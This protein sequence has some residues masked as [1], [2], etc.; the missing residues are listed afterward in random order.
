M[1][2]GSYAKKSMS[3]QPIE[4]DTY[5]PRR[6]TRLLPET[7]IEEEEEEPEALQLSTVIARTMQKTNEL[8]LTVRSKM[9]VD[10]YEPHPLKR[11]L[12][13]LKPL[14]ICG[15]ISVV[16][17]VILISAAALQRPGGTTLSYGQGG[18]V[19]TVDSSSWRVN[20]PLAPKVTLPPSTGPYSVLIAPTITA[21]T[22]N[23]V[24]ATYNSPAAGKGQALY[25]LG[26]KYQIDPTFALAF[27]LHESKFGTQ[28]EARSSLSLGNLRCID[29]A[30]CRDGYAWF[31][32]WEAGFEA[33]YQLIRNL[34]VAGWG[35]TTVDQIIPKYA[36]AADHNDEQAYINSVKHA[37]DV[38]RNGGIVV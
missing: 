22:I 37:I 20:Q 17:I 2:S 25:D 32:T 15:V 12:P 29:G 34:Y 27:F 36:P 3:Q 11:H 8:S 5:V 26:V 10:E 13:W 38:W 9:V 4:V 30:V 6:R 33:W 28:G 16:F 23:K 18:N 19:Y 31:P 7:T 21:D 24:L 1:A 14:I 35:R